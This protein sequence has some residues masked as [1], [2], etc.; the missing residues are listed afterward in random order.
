M[1]RSELEHVI[2]ASGAIA[3][4]DEI[5][6]IGSQSVLGQFPDAPARLL[7]SMETDIYPKNKPELAAMVDGSIGEG[8]FFHA[9]F[10][11]YAQGVG[12]T[13]AVLPEGWQERLVSVRNENTNGVTG[14]C[15]DVHDLAISKY[16]AGRPKD[17]QFTGEFRKRSAGKKCTSS[18]LWENWS[19]YPVPDL[20][21]LPARHRALPAEL[22]SPNRAQ[23][24]T[25]IRIP[26]SRAALCGLLRNFSILVPP[27]LPKIQVKSPI[28]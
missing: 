15:L 27:R 5:I 13:T 3:D 22:T 14:L 23:S 8:S 24:Y 6:V 26:V 21:V 25:Q 28:I 1:K 7:A 2:R 4:D 18:E 17:L 19:R 10:G 20:H 11:Y 9:E 16:V 12:P